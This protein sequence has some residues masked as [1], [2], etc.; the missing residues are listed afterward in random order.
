VRNVLAIKVDRASFKHSIKTLWESSFAVNQ[1][2]KV[3]QG[4][5]RVRQSGNDKLYPRGKHNVH[6]S[7][8]ALEIE[9]LEGNFDSGVYSR[10]DILQ[11]EA[12]GKQPKAA[13][14]TTFDSPA[15]AGKKRHHEEVA[16]PP[17]VVPTVTE[18]VDAD[19][20]QRVYDAVQ[21]AANNIGGDTE[22][23]EPKY[24]IGPLMVK[25]DEE[26]QP[27]LDPINSAHKLIQPAGYKPRDWLDAMQ[28]AN[29]LQGVT[30]SLP[31][32][33]FTYA[34]QKEFDNL[35]TSK[36]A[37]YIVGM[38]DEA[39]KDH[40]RTIKDSSPLSEAVLAVKAADRPDTEWFPIFCNGVPPNKRNK[41]AHHDAER[42]S[43]VKLK[44]LLVRHGTG[45]ICRQ[46]LVLPAGK[47]HDDLIPEQFKVYEE[48]DKEKEELMRWKRLV[49]SLNSVRMAP[50]SFKDLQE[51][52]ADEDEECAICTY[53]CDRILN[54]LELQR[55]K[56]PSAGVQNARALI[57]GPPGTGKTELIKAFAVEAG[58]STIIVQAK[59]VLSRWEGDADKV[60]DMYKKIA[61]V[62]QPSLVIIDDAEKLL[63]K[64]EGVGGTDVS[65]GWKTAIEG[66]DNGASQVA[67]IIITNYPD[68]IEAAVSNRV[69]EGGGKF[70]LPPPNPKRLERIYKNT[71]K[72]CRRRNVTRG[73]GIDWIRWDFQHIS[74][75]CHQQILG[76]IVQH[77]LGLR[78]M[79]S[80][81]HGA[82]AEA[83][84][85]PGKKDRTTFVYAVTDD[86]MQKSLQFKIGP[87]EPV[88]S[89]TKKRKGRGGAP[90]H[91]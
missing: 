31:G 46:M 25:K 33:F 85:V 87:T 88:H 82:M 29:D 72:D 22:A 39:A 42:L 36:R 5:F 57:H 38:P 58:I 6:G 10:W 32:T 62:Y 55:H 81:I 15:L 54:P 16:D 8:W 26:L 91:S 56:E 41:R 86:N 18:S 47:S 11:W 24:D 74:A 69:A 80:L 61:E 2:I 9:C 13:P 27:L 30:I 40:N 71:M 90:H 17:A 49:A 3:A 23:K 14:V 78:A 83:A 76:A 77:G 67:W 48:D 45:P 50:F 53:L 66:M 43:L 84:K 79:G 19:A 37:N 12:T 35:D 59:D 89:A 64:K 51:D 65:G 63:S 20:G 1:K 44:E 28:L 68:E 7:R 75:V 34:K 70:Q 73:I 52:A 21:A 60:V 4:S